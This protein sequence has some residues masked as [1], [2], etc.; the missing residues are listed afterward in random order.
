MNKKQ[1][2]VIAFVLAY[3]LYIALA[4]FFWGFRQGVIHERTYGKNFNVMN[5]YR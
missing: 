1:L 5:E 2:T 3:I 4:L